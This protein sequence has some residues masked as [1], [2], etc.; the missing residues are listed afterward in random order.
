MTL[1]H[2]LKSSDILSNN[3]K[4]K[5]V[6]KLRYEIKSELWDVRILTTVLHYYI[7]SQNYDIKSQ[8][9][10]TLTHNSDIKSKFWSVKS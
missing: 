3:Y 9:Y 8:M 5:S 1:N 7:K 2:R 6:I 4:M 10:E